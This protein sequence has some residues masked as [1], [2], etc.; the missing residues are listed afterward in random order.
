MLTLTLKVK[1]IKMKRKNN[2]HML[3]VFFPSF[4]GVGGG[5]VCGG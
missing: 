2:W 1:T 4:W 3:S 5:G